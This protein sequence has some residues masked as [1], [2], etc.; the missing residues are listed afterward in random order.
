VILAI[1]FFNNNKEGYKTQEEEEAQRIYDERAKIY[2]EDAANKIGDRISSDLDTIGD[3][4]S[5][6]LDVLSRLIDTSPN[7][8]EPQWR[9]LYGNGTDIPDTV[10]TGLKP[11]TSLIVSDGCSKKS[12]IKSDY[13]EDICEIYG[14]DFQ[15]INDKC[16]ALSNDNCNLPA[17]C[18]LLNGTKCVAGDINGP[19]YL[20][21][22]GNA[23]DYNYYLYRNKC[24]G[25]GCG[26]ATNKNKC[27]KYA[28]NSTGVSQ[29]CMV[30]MFNESGCTTPNPK[31]VVNSNYVYN[32]SKTSKQ[33]IQRDLKRIANSLLKDI[34]QGN[35]DSRIKCS[36]DPNNPCDQYLS[37]ETNISKACM[38]KM[39]NDAGCPSTI[40]K[41]ITNSFVNGNKDA[42][43]VILNKLIQSKTSEI[44]AAADAPGADPSTILSCYRNRNRT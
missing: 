15:K 2:G 20:T 12:I 27:G 18:I 34:T 39:V 29:D 21:D 16:K 5:S 13:A 3:S 44:K 28:K 23:I 24:Y 22:Q 42:D 37:K 7:V 33:Y 30:Q 10:T 41:M 19:S 38:I 43:K 17:C 31:H 36:A 32:N 26:N 11:D 1:L 6:G 9:S 4:T 8:S 25:A 40:P 14:G 35:T